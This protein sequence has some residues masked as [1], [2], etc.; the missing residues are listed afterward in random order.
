MVAIHDLKKENEEIEEQSSF[1]WY[2]NKIRVSSDE[3]DGMQK[4]LYRWKQAYREEEEEATRRGEDADRLRKQRNEWGTSNIVAASGDLDHDAWAAW[5]APTF[6][7]SPDI[8]GNL[9]NSGDLRFNSIGVKLANALMA[10]MQIEQAREV[11]NDAILQMAKSCRGSTPTLMKGRQFLATILD[12]F[13]SASNTDLVYTVR[14][15]YDLPYSGDNDI[16]TFKSQWD[17]VLECM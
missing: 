4:E 16:N 9:A 3:R 8:D 1:Y 5:V 15:L 10:M 12:S 2:R 11:L 6:A 14:H 17:E 13:R 7:I